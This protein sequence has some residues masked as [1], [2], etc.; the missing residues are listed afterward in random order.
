MKEQ[1]KTID[2]YKRALER[3]KIKLWELEGELQNLRSANKAYKEL[4]EGKKK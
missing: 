2:D 1:L 3:A 4:Y